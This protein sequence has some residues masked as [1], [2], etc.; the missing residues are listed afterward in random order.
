MTNETIEGLNEA[1]RDSMML[2][3]YHTR[4]WTATITDND[5]AQAA[6][7]A[8]GAP[9]TAFRVGKNLMA[10]HD[11][12]LKAVAVEMERARRTHY[13]NTWTWTDSTSGMRLLSTAKWMAYMTA[14]GK[15]KTAYENAL[16]DFVDHYEEDRDL[17]IAELK[18]PSAATVLYPAPSAIESYFM[19]KLDFAPIPAGNQFMGLPPSITKQLGDSYERR[20]QEKMENA[21]EGSFAAVREHVEGLIARLGKETPRLRENTFEQIKHA[22]EMI[23]LLN[24]TGDENLKEIGAMCRDL[25]DSYD[26][27]EI[28]TNSQKR[29]AMSADAAKI[30]NKLDAWGV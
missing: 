29:T 22:G 1:V 12:R 26:R 7:D 3:G 27:K 23:D 15:C 28:N 9:K 13:A 19:F 17:A 25:V 30:I 20:M 24:V 16:R 21:K 10:G 8:S 18:L 4:K 14:M 5:A 11:G 6:A 2:V